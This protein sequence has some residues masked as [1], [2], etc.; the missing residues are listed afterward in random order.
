MYCMLDLSPQ[1]ASAVLLLASIPNQ[2]YVKKGLFK[3]VNCLNYLNYVLE[4]G[5][6]PIEQVVFLPTEDSIYK[7]KTQNFI[8]RCKNHQIKKVYLYGFS[9][10]LDI[11]NKFK[12]YIKPM[13]EEYDIE[14]ITEDKYVLGQ[15]FVNK[16]S[17]RI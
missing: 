3:K 10:G 17:W 14:I 2:F 11:E 13:L 6:Y 1:T 12:N 8:Y 4:Q 7:E 5:D 9:D 16:N 15:L